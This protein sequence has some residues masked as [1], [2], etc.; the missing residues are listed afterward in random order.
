MSRPSSPVLLAW[1]LAGALALF[2]AEAAAGAVT[3]SGLKNIAIPANFEGVYLDLAT[4]SSGASE[5]SGWDLNFFFGG[6]GVA[7]SDSLLPVLPGSA[8]VAS[9][10][11]IRLLSLG[12]EVK[13]TSI[14]TDGYGVS[15]AE[16]NSGHLGPGTSQFGD[17]AAGYMGFKLNR[18]SDTPVYG[19]MQVVLTRNGSGIIKDWAYE[20]SGASIV[21]GFEGFADAAPVTTLS[22]GETSVS[23]ATLAGNVQ[24]G[25]DAA[26]TFAE[27][28]TTQGTFAGILVGSGTLNI[29]GGGGLYLSGTNPF[30]GT[31]AVGGGS[32]L[33]IDSNQNLGSAS[34]VLNGG[35]ALVFAADDSND[36]GLNTFRNDITVGTTGTTVLN[37]SGDGEVTL[38]GALGGGS[39]TSVITKTGTGVMTLSGDIPNTYSGTIVVSGGELQLQKTSGNAIGGN[40][41]I[42]GGTLNVAGSDQI[43]D[44][45]QLTLAPG[46]SMIFTGTGLTETIGTLTN[47]GG[48]FSTGANSLTGSGNSITWS[49]SSTNT[50]SNGGLLA[51]A[52]FA[53]SGGTNTVEGGAAGGVLQVLTGGPGLELA[54]G[55]T[56]TL[57]SDNAVP[58]KL[59]LQGNVSVAGAATS[60]TIASGLALANRGTIDLDG[61]IRTFAVGDGAA[62]VDLM[63]SASLSNGGLIKSGS[64]TMQLSAP[65]GYSGSTAIGAGTLE[66]AGSAASLSATSALSIDGGTLL[67]TGTGGSAVNNAAAITLGGVSAAPSTLQLSGAV[68]ETL[69]NLTLSGTTGLR[70]IDFGLGSGILTL[71]VLDGA[72]SGRSLQVWNWS[73]LGVVGGGTDQ[74]ILAGGLGSN[75]SLSDISFY[76]D[77]GISGLGS[78]A[79]VAGTA[80]EVTVSIATVPEAGS[81]GAVLALLAPLAWR[82]RR[83]YARCRE[84]RRAPSNP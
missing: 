46:G 65:N 36:T 15:G 73:G 40:L 51:D 45:A 20:T 64:G 59:L 19:W 1:P 44:N 75:L 22:T 77:S 58:G 84:A 23:S 4:G 10:S 39:S 54:S 25:A 63:I 27:S 9:G 30:S 82:E 41:T 76:S 48:T 71:N 29:T 2:G 57:K 60:A 26:I 68:T 69:G 33:T 62:A 38:S 52:H 11:S 80:G 5:F 8:G 83:H 32:N 81:L 17:G 55:A 42:S 74:L 7:N 28:G 72:T 31:I 61:G 24:L 6:L 67:L 35:A 14:F 50:V 66:L 53:I 18:P 49:G 79:W 70:V 12:G 13:R 21:S 43:A 56:L 78:A 34:V 3:Y 47:S 16:D 37:N